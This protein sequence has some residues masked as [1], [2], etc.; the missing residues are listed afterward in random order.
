M[1]PALSE[2]SPRYVTWGEGTSDEMCPAI[3]TVGDS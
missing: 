3:L 1:L 2:S